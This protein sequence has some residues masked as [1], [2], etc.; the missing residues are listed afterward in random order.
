M[1]SLLLYIDKK[2]SDALHYLDENFETFSDCEGPMRPPGTIRKE[3]DKTKH[4]Q[5]TFVLNPP[6]HPYMKF[7]LLSIIFQVSDLYYATVHLISM[8]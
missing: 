8:Q 6:R 2:N 1:V 7:H 3:L 5:K 4:V